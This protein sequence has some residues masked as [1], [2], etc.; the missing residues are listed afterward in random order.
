VRQIARKA[1]VTHT[2]VQHIANGEGSPELATLAAVGRVF[3]MSLTDMVA[4]A[5]QDLRVNSRRLEYRVGNTTD[6]KWLLEVFEEL[7][8]DDREF[9]LEL[10]ERLAGKSR[11]RVIGEDNQD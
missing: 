2:T 3:G 10:A 4:L 7:S 11:P 1:G 6:G 8:S 5:E 9:L